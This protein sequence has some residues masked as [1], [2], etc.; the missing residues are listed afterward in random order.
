MNSKKQFIATIYTKDGYEYLGPTNEGDNYNDF[1]TYV[2]QEISDDGYV[3]CAEQAYVY[4]F[5]PDTAMPT[6]DPIWMWNDTIAI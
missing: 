4:E 6:G 5:S 1:I 2:K 3:T